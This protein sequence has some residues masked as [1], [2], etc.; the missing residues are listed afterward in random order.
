MK[1]LTVVKPM[2]PTIVVK[3]TVKKGGN[4]KGCKK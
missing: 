1:K 3:K 2:K 4:K